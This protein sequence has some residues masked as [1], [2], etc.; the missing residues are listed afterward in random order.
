MIELQDETTI[1]I[2]PLDLD[3]INPN[4]ANFM[5][6]NQ[7]GSKIFIIGKSGSGKSTLIRSLF[8][9]KSQIIPVAQ[10]MSGTESETGFYRQFI[11]SAYIFDEYDSQ[12]L[13]NM[14]MRQKAA[15]QYLANPWTMLIIDDC[16]DE[17]S[18]FNKTPQPALFKNGRHWKMLYLVALQYALD[19]KPGIRSNIDG[20]FIFRESNVAIRKRL[21]D[22]YAGIIP[23]FQLFEK[24]MDEITKDYTAL[25]IHN[26]TTSNDWRDCVF[27]YKA[28]F[29]NQHVDQFKFGCCEYRGYGAKILKPHLK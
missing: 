16:M 23:T 18:V 4:P 5:D 1:K 12:A 9:N 7:G 20:V 19:V 6:P 26:V 22:N 10:A 14:I 25:Y 11:P 13:G 2:K 27:Y 29:E 8:Y 24:I 3:M 17:T 21:Y 15:R 28:P